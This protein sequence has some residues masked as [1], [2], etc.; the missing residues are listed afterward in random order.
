MKSVIIIGSGPSLCKDD[1]DL[2]V[3]DGRDIVSVN[4]SWV[5]SPKCKYVFSG[6]LNWW[7]HNYNKLAGYSSL[8]TSSF[9]ASKIY[10]LNYMVCEAFLT[11]SGAKAIDFAVK[12]GYEHIVLLGF[13][14][15]LS[16]RGDTHWHGDHP[17]GLGN[18]TIDSF[19]KWKLQFRELRIKT[20][21]VEIVN[22][23]RSSSI[24]AFPRS[25]LSQCLIS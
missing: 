12:I 8:W 21:S 25:P 16:E 9:K 19:N 20:P 11:N 13:D 23:S 14:C 24:D 15:E 22:C 10:S 7:N 2:C 5:L 6:D 1:V 18:P 4:S 17:A 3:S